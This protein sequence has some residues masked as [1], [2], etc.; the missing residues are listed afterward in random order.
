MIQPPPSPSPLRR[1]GGF[2]FWAVLPLL[3]GI[4]LAVALIPKPQIGIIRFEDSIWYYSNEYLNEL[5]DRAST[6]DRIR[7]VVLQL[8]S[9]GGAVIYTEELFFHL[10]EL[11]KVKPLVVS[12]DSM[13][14]SGGYYMAVAG[15]VVFAKP[16][17]IVGNVGV[18]SSLPSTDDQRF[19]DESYVSTGPSKFSGGSRG[20][21]MRRIELLKLGFLES[22]FSQRGDK[23]SIDRQTLANGEIFLGLQAKQ[24]G[25]IDELG[26]TSEAVQKAAEMARLAR[27]DVVDVIDLVYGSQ[28]SEQEVVPLEIDAAREEAMSQQGL[29]YLYIEPEQRRQ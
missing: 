28:E 8:D 3:A 20:D 17:S 21:Y 22:V 27:Y 15:D 25:L 13:A 18:I 6:D 5:L 23:L 2:L 14:A 9:P 11:R 19:T 12:I 10:L 26:A 16:A 29:Y 7:A 4:L 1:L 24:L